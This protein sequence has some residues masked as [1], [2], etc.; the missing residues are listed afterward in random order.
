MADAALI[1]QTAETLRTAANT[2]V[3]SGPVQDILGSST[4]VA[5]AYAVQ[6]MNHKMALVRR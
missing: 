2:A 4:D 1:E 3:T 5:A 6:D